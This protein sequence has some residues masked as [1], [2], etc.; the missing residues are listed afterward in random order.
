MAIAHSK[1]TSWFAALLVALAMQIYVS[2][3]LHD[4]RPTLTIVEEPPTRNAVELMALGDDSFYFRILALEL[5]NSGDSYGR[6]TALRYYDYARL[7]RW[8]ALLDTLDARS[9]IVPT[10]A[11]YYYALTPNVKDIAA[12]VQYLEE[13]ADTNPATKWWWYAQAT[14]LAN[15]KLKDTD[16][17]LRLAYKL[18]ESP[19][20]MPMW[21]KQMPAFIHE[22][23]G[24]LEDSYRFMQAIADEFDSLSNAEKNF[25]VYFMKER[26]AALE[27][28][29]VTAEAL[30][31]R[32]R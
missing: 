16:H 3:L 18:S 25:I 14:Y 10:L 31:K 1:N 30:E 32:S 5:Q 13:H 12:V 29:Q 26:M 11:S 27:E 8:F 2:G 15:H 6:F 21:A 7:S 19:A 24:E 17:A 4:T 23:R 9:N 20:K 28:A 22:Q